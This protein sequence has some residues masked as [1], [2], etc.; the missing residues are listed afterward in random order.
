MSTH[1]LDEVAAAHLPGEWDG[2]RWLA[3]RLNRGELRG[4]RFGRN[5]RMRD[6]DIDYMLARY[7]NDTDI[8]PEPAFEPPALAVIDGLSE[9]SRRNLKSVRG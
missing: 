9:R 8:Q 4:V 3:A 7:A 5:W 1:S 6:S 2:R